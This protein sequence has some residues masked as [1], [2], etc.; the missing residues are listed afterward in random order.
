MAKSGS[1]GRVLITGA[2]SGIGRAASQAFAAEGALVLAVARSRERLDSLAAE[3]SG[4]GRIIPLVADVTDGG[5]MEKLAARVLSE[6]GAPDVIIANAGISLDATFANTTDEA[7]R[8]VFEVNVLGVLRTVRPFLAGMIAHRRGRI[9]LISSVVGKRGIP[10]YT[11]YSASKFALHGMADA[12]RVE[13][14]GTGVTVGVV[15]PSSTVT[16]LTE[17]KLRSGPQQRSVRLARHSAESVA[18]AILRMARSR[19][20]EIVLSPEGKL[21]MWANAVAPSL[22]DGILARVLL[23]K[24]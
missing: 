16:E 17:R 24:S 2:S 10:N 1:G 8:A 6:H 4:P 9:L 18:R 20:R 22:I 19:R 7:F 14:R 11:A 3:H 13:L 12:L 21:M 5:S 15:C 23:R